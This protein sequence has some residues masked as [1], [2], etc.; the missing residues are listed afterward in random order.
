MRI[1]VSIATMPG[2]DV[3]F[4]LRSLISQRRPPDV[5]FVCVCEEYRREPGARVDTAQITSHPSV[6]I[7]AGCKDNGPATKLLGSLNAV[8]EFGAQL[9]VLADDDLQYVPSALGDV[10]AYYA[11]HGLTRPSSCYVYS[12]V[13]TAIGQGAD[14]FAMPVHHLVGIEDFFVAQ[15]TMHPE[16]WYHDDVLISTF[17]A[18]QRLAVRFRGS[19]C[20][21]YDAE[22]DP[23]NGL[24][25][26]QGRVARDELN[27]RLRPFV[28]SVQ[29]AP[30]LA[31]TALVYGAIGFTL[32]IVLLA[33]H[34]AADR[35]AA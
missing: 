17:F 31:E 10:E 19:V 1:T 24:Q 14:L 15:T 8:R 33:L 6:R 29:P 34:A 32:L 20:R 23:Q 26:M 30:T 28:R 25:H 22:A 9:L 7:I 11:T 16:L 5:I 4:S 2:R 18:Q 35:A 27:R 3:N 21:T 13:G 12:I